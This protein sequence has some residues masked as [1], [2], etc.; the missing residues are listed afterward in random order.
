MR[1]SLCFLLILSIILLNTHIL[2]G[3]TMKLIEPIPKPQFMITSEG[4]FFITNETKLFFDEFADRSSFFV[5]EI[6]KEIENFFNQKIKLKVS[7]QKPSKNF[8]YFG[9]LTSNEYAWQFKE[10]IQEK[11]LLDRKEGYILSVDKNRIAILASHPQGAFYG[12]MSLLQMLQLNNSKKIFVDGVVIVDFPAYEMRGISDDIARGQVSTL[13]DFKKIIRTIARYKMNVYQ[14]YF[15]DAIELKSFPDIGLN[16]SRLSQDEIKELIK[17]AE[18]YFVQIIP[19]FQTL[20]HWENLLIQPNYYHLADFPG[21]ASLDVTNEQTYEFLD[22]CIAELSEIF[23]SK[24]FHAGLDESWDVGFGNSKE[25]TKQIGIAAVHA[26]HYKRVNEIIKKYGKQMMMYGD[27]IHNHPEIFEM[28]PKDI[29]VVDW[30]YGVNDYEPIVKKYKEHNQPFI[31]SPSVTNYNRIFPHIINSLLNIQLFAKVSY[32]YGSIGF[33]NS[34]WGDNGG[35]NLREFNWF[36]YAFGAECSWN[37]MNADIYNFKSKFF[38]DFYGVDNSELDAVYTFLNDFGASFTQYDFWRNPFVKWN[39]TIN[40]QEQNFILFGETIKSKAKTTLDLIQKLKTHSLKNKS[41]LDYLEFVANQALWYGDKLSYSVNIK[42]LIDKKNGFLSKDER[43]FVKN[44]CDDMIVRLEKLKKEFRELWLRTNK[45]KGLELIEKEKYDRQIFA[46]KKMKENLR[47]EIVE[48][49][50][51]IKS[52]WMFHPDAFP[53]QK[54]QPQVEEAIFVRD[55][56]VKDKVTSAL[57]HLMA[58][59]YAEL[60][61]NDNLIGD[62]RGRRTLSLWVES[63]RAKFFDITNYLKPGVNKIKIVAKNFGE[64]VS[65]GVNVQIDLK[66]PISHHR[67]MPD[68]SWKVSR[69]GT[70]FI[71]PKLL[72]PKF[73]SSEPDFENRITSWYE[74]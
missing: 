8:I 33:I 19:I 63:Q 46:W 30:R 41:H 11:K 21:A 56:I 34:N 42:K 10:I 38:R 73:V 52:N 18:Q 48:Y 66:T 15:E 49:D 71:E 14:P 5:S 20:G 26:N 62:V 69:D 12:L 60:Y 28:L 22:K 43:E 54:N 45:E 65:A 32:E 58:D 2:S 17:Y 51:T 67:I 31:C 47:Q 13:D 4:K 61:V 35:E 25:I 50:Q 57:V 70:N 53:G 44:L 24:Y 3:E 1:L 16:R 23:P 64:N 7:K 40:Y 59:S 72:P 74:R 9:S 6:E 36:G 39:N 27:I 29:I 55:L 37:P 68:E